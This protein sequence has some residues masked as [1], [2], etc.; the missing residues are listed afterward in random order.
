VAFKNFARKKIICNYVRV[1]IIKG[2]NYKI[3]A[4]YNVTNRLVG[5]RCPAGNNLP[6]KEKGQLLTAA[7]VGT[8]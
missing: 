7:T 4:R 1:G 6:Q 8:L 2:I 5:F 3:A